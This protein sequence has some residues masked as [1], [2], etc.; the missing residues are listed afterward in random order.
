M[1]TVENA[2]SFS[3]L[4]ARRTPQLLVIYTGGFASPTEIRL[5]RAVRDLNPA[6][7]LFH[8]GDLDAGGLRILAHLRGHLGDIVPLAMDT[9]TFHTRRG[10]GQ[11]LTATDR[12][13][14]TKLATHPLLAD[15]TQLIATLL[16]TDQ[17][18]E[19]EAV[20][21]EDLLEA[22]GQAMQKMRR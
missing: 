21:A 11:R 20:S 9:P 17:K 1:I 5:L 16:E 13:A 2:T 6:L 12:A 4:A 8:W 3:E 19:Q 22:L 10:Q 7:S 18:L 14:L 15:C